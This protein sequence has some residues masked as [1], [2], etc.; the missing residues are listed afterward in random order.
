MAVPKK[1]TLTPSR[2]LIEWTD[3][4]GSVFQ[5]R[6]LREAC[7]CALCKGEPSPIGFS[8]TIPLVPAAPADVAAVRF[9]MVG[10]YAISFSWSDG[11]SSGIYPFGYLLEMCGC[12]RCAASKS[13][14]HVVRGD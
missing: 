14:P 9:S 4:H 5:N 7:P 8:T 11:H 12:D 10:R 2:V 6:E 1:V 3:G 13:A